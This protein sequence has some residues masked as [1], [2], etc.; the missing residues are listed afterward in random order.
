[1][2]QR[3]KI[4]SRIFTVIGFVILLSAI[5]LYAFA[6]S[7]LHFGL[8]PIEFIVD[9]GIAT[10]AA[11]VVGIALIVT[12]ACEL[13]IKKSKW[14]EIEEKDERNVAIARAAKATGYEVMTCLFSIS[15]VVLSFL[16]TMS[17]LAF[18]TLVAVF[19]ISQAVFVFRLWHLHKVM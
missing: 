7:A 11:C 4:M 5:T 19:F 12:G 8:G 14:A 6:G 3:N 15:I 2:N 1:M 13:L 18:F 9:K 17:N 16:G 10:L